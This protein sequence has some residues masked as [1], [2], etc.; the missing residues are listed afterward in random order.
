MLKFLEILFWGNNC[1]LCEYELTQNESEICSDC[2]KAL[3]KDSRLR[4]IGRKTWCVFDYEG[5]V[6]SLILNGKYRFNLKIWTLWKDLIP[7][8]HFG[9]DN[10][11]VYVPM[12]FGRY[13]FRGF[14]QSFLIGKLLEDM[15]YGK[16]KKILK[17][18]KFKKSSSLQ[19]LDERYKNVRGVFELI[20]GCEEL[21]DKK[22]I[23][24]DDV[25]TTGATMDEI[26]RI[27]VQ[28]GFKTENISKFA[29]ASGRLKDD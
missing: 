8:L 3:V 5:R 15:G 28:A 25:V 26:E 13:C 12:T 18:V 19:N 21:K 2:K 29:L 16:V 9:S 7:N 6:R 22:V 4:K 23:V 20:Q 11:I 27:L 14:N 17:R 1:K 10:L 24:V